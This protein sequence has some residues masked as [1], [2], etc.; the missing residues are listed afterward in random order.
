MFL[1]FS[2]VL[3]YFFQ[4]KNNFANLINDLLDSKKLDSCD[5]SSMIKQINSEFYKD[6]DKYLYQSSPNAPESDDGLMVNLH[7]D[8]SSEKIDEKQMEES[9]LDVDEHQEDKNEE[10]TAI[11]DEK[12]KEKGEDSVVKDD[13]KFGVSDEEKNSIE[14]Q[15]IDG[16]NCE[17][18]MIFQVQDIFEEFME[19]QEFDIGDDQFR[20]IDSMSE[21]SEPPVDESVDTTKESQG[22]DVT[23]RPESPGELAETIKM[24]EKSLEIMKDKL[25]KI[26]ADCVEMSEK[27]SS[28]KSQQVSPVVE[29]DD[30]KS[31]IVGK[32]LSEFI[33][34][35]SQEDSPIDEEKTENAGQ[36]LG[37]FND[38]KEEDIIDQDENITDVKANNFEAENSP[39]DPEE[40]NDDKIM[41]KEVVRSIEN[42][43]NKEDNESTPVTENTDK[44]KSENI[45]ID[46][47]DKKEDSNLSVSDSGP[48][49]LS[50]ACQ[51]NS[52]K[53]EISQ[54]KNLQAVIPQD[55]NTDCDSTI[56]KE[57]E[58][59][60]TI[61]FEKVA[62]ENVPE[63]SEIILS[64]KIAT[65]D[66]IE[67]KNPETVKIFVEI[68][69]Q[70]SE[71]EK[72]STDVIDNEEAPPDSDEINAEKIVNFN[73]EMSENKLEELQT[74]EESF[75]KTLDV[76]EELV[77]KINSDKVDPVLENVDELSR[78][79]MTYQVKENIDADQE[80]ILE[81]VDKCQEVD[82]MTEE[83]EKV[84]EL[85]EK[86]G[87]QEVEA[88]DGEKNEFFEVLEE[89][90]KKV[91]E[92]K[93]LNEV[94]VVGEIEDK[95]IDE[96]KGST[97]AAELREKENC[98]E[99]NQ[100]KLI[101]EN[102]SEDLSEKI[103][104]NNLEEEIGGFKDGRKSDEF[105]VTALDN[106]DEIV[107]SDK[108][109]NVIAKILIDEKKCAKIVVEE[110]K[111]DK[112]IVEEKKF[113]DVEPEE[114]DCEQ[115][116]L[117][118]ISYLLDKFSKDDYYSQL[119]FVEDI[120][121][122]KI[123]ERSVAM[124]VVDAIF[125]QAKNIPVLGFSLVCVLR[126]F[127]DHHHHFFNT[128]MKISFRCEH[129]LRHHLLNRMSDVQLVSNLY[130]QKLIPVAFIHK[131][132]Q[133]FFAR[134]QINDVESLCQLIKLIHREEIL[135][136][137]YVEKLRK[138]CEFKNISQKRINLIHNTLFRSKKWQDVW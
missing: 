125:T 90:V 108:E 29:I 40:K 1:F 33:E 46:D 103:K 6:M 134:N 63:S 22:I 32:V 43:E 105:I 39:D 74:K 4:F 77:E 38:E 129:E 138:Y 124:N 10:N 24:V 80:K 44:D 17:V 133:Y 49:E 31:E 37:E 56:L 62:L 5:I 99:S 13:E 102:I 11:I 7:L 132:I 20:D 131:Y 100:E 41:A 8:E 57:E 55:E 64:E 97:E 23:L 107:V 116:P 113:E 101:T 127:A 82:L 73:A 81:A 45:E 104:V 34:E 83:E 123:R 25:C 21:L 87:K 60:M 52:N 28:E 126:N 121:K 95:C 26:G 92:N 78:E 110:G 58:S 79:E 135:K 109:K 67:N 70:N 98:P 128:E 122:L 14:E 84:E 65:Q 9:L 112:I 71:K 115:T 120:K 18:K 111:F 117:E 47:G 12:N 16:N 75:E 54:D 27:Y 42:L 66:D 94:Q 50:S 76:E 85:D 36:V 3:F 69:Q 35:K 118:R 130:Q 93:G 19:P 91:E 59:S 106:R 61:E 88:V 96:E 89:L 68:K 72:A 30:E 2:N 48:S 15:K 137:S 51:E 53:N 136:T 119:N 114:F 86:K